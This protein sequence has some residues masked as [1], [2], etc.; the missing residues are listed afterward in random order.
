MSNKEVSVLELKD[1]VLE[2]VAETIEVLKV[3][4]ID[5]KGE[6]LEENLSK[7]EWYE[8]VY[9]DVQKASSIDLDSKYQLWTGT[10]NFLSNIFDMKIE[11]LNET[12]EN[13]LAFEHGVEL[14]LEYVNYRDIMTLSKY[15]IES[16]SEKIIGLKDNPQLF[17]DYIY[18]NN[19]DSSSTFNHTYAEELNLKENIPFNIV[20]FNTPKW[21]ESLVNEHGDLF[22]DYYAKYYPN[23]DDELKTILGKLP[24]LTHDIENGL[25]LPSS[26]AKLLRIANMSNN[27]ELILDNIS[28]L[29]LSELE[30][31]KELVDE[32]N[33]TY[34]ASII[35]SSYSHNL[36]ISNSKAKYQED[37]M[38]R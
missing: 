27:E 29:D 2:Y 1:Y 38:S 10:E 25:S 17:R 37:E 7:L 20:N 31:L 9:E 16:L 22:G 34:D 6:E 32:K 4:Q 28:G 13:T 8:E 33:M 26:S 5:L 30:V 21:S 19:F 18:W 3:E 35:T 15:G 24:R 11:D 36:D 23:I 12:F 14:N